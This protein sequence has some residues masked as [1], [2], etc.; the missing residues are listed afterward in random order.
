MK[1]DYELLRFAYQVL[2]GI[3]EERFAPRLGYYIGP[4]I[5]H[6]RQPDPHR[7]GTLACGGGWIAMHP[8]FRA[9]GIYINNDGFIC[10]RDSLEIWQ[11][12]AFA[13]VFRITEHEAGRLFGP[14][15]TN[16]IGTPKQVMLGRIRQLL[17]DHNQL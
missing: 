7:C 12:T 2:G 10:H 11:V 5:E 8:T 13:I 9:K 3:P 17:N 1:P 14:Q 6:W 4:S 15:L 16:E